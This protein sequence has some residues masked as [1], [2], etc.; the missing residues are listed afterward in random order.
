MT[1]MEDV[2]SSERFGLGWEFTREGYGWAQDGWYRETVTGWQLD[3]SGFVRYQGR[4]Y[5]VTILTTENPNENYGVSTL[6]TIA[7]DVWKFLK[8]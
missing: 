4:F 7:S 3:T 8:P 2:I 6:T 1:L 5:L